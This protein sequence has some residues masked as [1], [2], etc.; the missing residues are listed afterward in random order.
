MSRGDRMLLR[1]SQGWKWS[2]Y[3]VA[4][5]QLIS[6]SGFSLVFPFLPFYVESLGTRTHI[7]MEFWTGMVFSALG[8]T[9]M[10][11]SP[12]WGAVADRYGR[13]PMVIR[14]MLGGS[15]VM[16]LMSFARSAEELVLLRA[17]Q[18]MITGTAAATNAIVAAFTPRERVGY[19]MGVMQTAYWIGISL[20]P[21]AGGAVSDVAGYRALFLM[22]SALLFIGGISVILGIHEDF[23]PVKAEGK[24]FLGFVREWYEVLRTPGIV[25]AF[26]VRF[27]GQGSKQLVLPFIPLFAKMLLSGHSNINTL[28]GLM[29]SLASAATVVTAIQMGKL[30]DRIGH[31]TVLSAS[32][33]LSAL[34][35]FPQGLSRTGI[36]LLV[37][38]VLAG[39]AA[40]GFG[41]S[42]GALL[43]RYVHKGQE[44]AVY[45]LD[46]STVAASRAIAP[47]VGA[48]VASALGIRWVFVATGGV[49]LVAAIAAAS[50]MPKDVPAEA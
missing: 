44:G 17:L 28:T 1:K 5:A 32:L 33:F 40:G 14:A 22:A 35:Y 38:Q 34:I 18:G 31:K 15:A 4:F 41:S 8:L 12:L 36:D 11:S 39:A 29:M 37:L 3:V 9:M 30:G 43:A 26:L 21:V 48:G 7:G 16:L 10:I 24:R 49:L 13:K 20:G 25:S 50:F 27:L 6:A 23:V 46:N 2:L 19:A 45:G 42:L 47:M